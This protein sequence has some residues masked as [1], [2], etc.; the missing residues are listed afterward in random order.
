MWKE[1]CISASMEFNIRNIRRWETMS[2]SPLLS[3]GSKT[4]LHITLTWLTLEFK[5]LVSGW[6]P[7]RSHLNLWGWDPGISRAESS[8]DD[9]IVQLGLRSSALSQMSTLTHWMQRC[10]QVSWFLNKWNP[11]PT[12]PVSVPHLSFTSNSQGHGGGWFP[13]LD[14]LPES[15]GFPQTSCLSSGLEVISFLRTLLDPDMRSLCGWGGYRP[16]S[17]KSW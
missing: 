14:F 11:A 6:H 16:S 1:N 4:W 15:E 10:R 8:Q 17:L 9:C 2:S 13:F 3:S 7:G 12:S 5:Y